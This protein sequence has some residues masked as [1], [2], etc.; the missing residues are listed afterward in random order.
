VVTTQR[1]RR[2][3]VPYLIASLCAQAYRSVWPIPFVDDSLV[4]DLLFGASFGV[5]YYVFLLFWLIL[6]TPVIAQIPRPYAGLAVAVSM[7]ATLVFQQMHNL[8]DPSGLSIFWYQRNP[9]Q[10]IGYFAVGWYARLNHAALVNWLV[11]RRRAVV[12][13]LSMAVIACAGLFLA[14]VPQIAASRAHDVAIYFVIALIFAGFC[15]RVG[16]PP[17]VRTLSDASYAIY[18][19]HPF[20]VFPL[21][22]VFATGP[23]WPIAASFCAGLTGALTIVAVAR[24]VLRRYAR[25]LLGA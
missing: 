16:T 3:L 25:P 7:A 1:L 12:A 6:A 14:R 10:V 13:I 18:L 5:Y 19:F 24:I 21:R 20:F 23:I 11:P 15:G 2:L 22:Q 17:V 4:S 8:V 9:L